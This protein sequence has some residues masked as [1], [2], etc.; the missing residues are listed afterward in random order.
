MTFYERY[1]RVCAEKGLDP[2]AQK[3][4]EMIGVARATI[5]IWNTKNT[6]PKGET[7]LAI[8][9]ALHVSTDYLLGRTDDPTDTI[10]QPA[11]RYTQDES[12][13]LEKLERLDENDRAKVEAYI[14]G[15]L[16]VGKYPLKKHQIG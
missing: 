2:C 6:A 14:D 7:V 16:S 5:S 13:I 4:A 3:T 11:A 12:A 9:D 1:A 10:A 15:M 8:A